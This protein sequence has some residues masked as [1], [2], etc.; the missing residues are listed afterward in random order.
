MGESDGS[1]RQHSFETTFEIRLGL[2]RPTRMPTDMLPHDIDH[3][4]SDQTVLYYEREQIR[5][6]VLDDGAHDVDTSARVRHCA[7]LRQSFR[8][9]TQIRTP[10]LAAIRQVAHIE[11]LRDLRK[12]WFNYCILS[13]VILTFAA[14]KIIVEYWSRVLPGIS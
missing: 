6:S 12:V 5:C 8:V 1:S 3:R 7:V 9:D 14:T 4:S 10:E 13:R 2:M 11:N